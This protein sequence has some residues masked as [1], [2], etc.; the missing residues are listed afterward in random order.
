MTARPGTNNQTRWLFLNSREVAKVAEKA[1]RDK[2]GAPV[3]SMRNQWMLFGPLNI[4]NGS[5]FGRRRYERVLG[6]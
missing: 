3:N 6:T 4:P 1:R 2:I 5:R